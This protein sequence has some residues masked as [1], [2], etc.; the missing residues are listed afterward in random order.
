MAKVYYELFFPMASGTDQ[1]QINLIISRVKASGIPNIRILSMVTSFNIVP[2]LENVVTQLSEAGFGV[3]V[4]WD[5]GGTMVSEATMGELCSIT[6]AETIFIISWMTYGGW[7]VPTAWLKTFQSV[8]KATGHN[9]GFLVAGDLALVEVME[10]LKGSGIIAETVI[11][12]AN[13][14]PREAYKE[15]YSYQWQF[16]WAYTPAS[17]MWGVPAIF[18]PATSEEIKTVVDGLKTFLSADGTFNNMKKLTV[19]FPND[20]MPPGLAEGI[21]YLINELGVPVAPD[22]GLREWWNSLPLWQ[23]TSIVIGSVAAVAG[24]VYTIKRIRRR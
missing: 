21:T 22:G 5:L 2:R 19:R 6:R 14:P 10:F 11:Q 23:K 12:P 18:E 13:L 17:A 4:R 7:G 8:A 9:F 15:P 3:D 16:R 24:S 1:E 20:V